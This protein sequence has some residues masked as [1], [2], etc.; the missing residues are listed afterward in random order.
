MMKYFILYFVRTR[1]Q[2]DKQNSNIICKIILILII[3]IL[4]D[5]NLLF[6]KILM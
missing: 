3:I 1:L 6:R 4:T 5:D 2:N